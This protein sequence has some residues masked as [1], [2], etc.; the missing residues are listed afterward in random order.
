[1]PTLTY[2]IHDRRHLQ[3]MLAQEKRVNSIFDIFISSIAPEMRKWNE[4]SNKSVWVR[5]SSIE[6]KINLQLLNLQ[7][8][9]EKE[10]RANQTDAWMSAIEKNDLI[11]EQ[12]IKGMALSSVAKEGMF[13]RNLEGL[14]ALQRRVD[15]GMNLSDRVWNITN[16]TKGHVELFL[17]SGL[18]A[19]RSAEGIGRDMRQ[20]LNNP[21]KRFRRVRNEEGKL[22]L[23]QPMK[24]Y[25][26]GQGVYRSSRMNALRLSATETNMGYRMSDVERWEQLDFVLGYEVK[27]SPNAEPCAICDALKGKYP[28]GFVFSAFHP[29]CICYAVPIV[30]EHNDFADFLLDRTPKGQIITDIPAQAKEFLEKNPKYLQGSYYGKMNETFLNAQSGIKFFVDKELRTKTTQQKES[31]QEKWNERKLYNAIEN[32]ENKIRMNKK[33]ETGVAFDSFGKIVLDKRGKA[34]SVSFTQDECRLVKDAFFTHNHPRGWSAKENTIG[35]IGNSFS[36]EDISF[37]IVNDVAEIR[38]VTPTFTFIMK[39]PE[40]GWPIDAGEMKKSVSEIETQIKN[41]LHAMISRSNYDA[42]TL[43]RANTCHYH[44]LWKR[45]SKKHG[46]EYRK[47]KSEGNK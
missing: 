37:A 16:Q 20:M 44:L 31:I 1:M 22:V 8:T 40:K 18:A 23:S 6:H 11:V 7:R 35:R 19:G 43:D 45:F 41:E 47:F 24:N 21:D 9:L 28:K 38:A 34:T 2:S 30:M 26:P 15:N 4:T 29:F 12:Y 17:E 14:K 10:I 39:R 27:R 5:N 33:Y 3:R 36:K 25:H 32:T 42:T 13:S 46:I